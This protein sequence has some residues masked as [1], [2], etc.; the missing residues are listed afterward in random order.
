MTG[1]IKPTIKC[2]LDELML[3]FNLLSNLRGT[4]TTIYSLLVQYNYHNLNVE[5]L[6][7]LGHDL[8][9]DYDKLVSH[10]RIDSQSNNKKFTYKK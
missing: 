5:D 10:Y 1:K 3:V 4:Q 8:L 2:T 6:N 9:D 7:Q